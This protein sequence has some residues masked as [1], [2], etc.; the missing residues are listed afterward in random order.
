VTT[1]NS[2]PAG[3]IALQTN[4]GCFGGATGALDLVPSGGS[5]PYT[6]IWSN[7][8]TTEDV[9]NLA[10]GTFNVIITDANNCKTAINATITQP[11]AA[12]AV[13]AS[14][15]DVSCFGYTNGSAVAVV[16]GGT[17]PYSYSWDT[18]PVQ[19]TQTVADLAPGTY[20]VNIT[21]AMG[22]L[23]LQSVQISEPPELAIGETH[24]DASC[25]DEPDGFITLT[26]TGGTGPYSALWSD[27]FNTLNRADIDTGNYRVIVTDS[28]GCSM[29]ADIVIDFEGTFNCVMIPQVITPN[30]DGYNDTWIIRN[31]DLYPNAEVLVFNRWGD[32]IFRTKNIL[33]NPW[34]GTFKG[35]LVPTDSYHYILYLNDGS[36]PK[37]GVI[38]VIR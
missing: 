11:I 15:T 21:D 29:P 28:L 12:L 7:G 26:V 10:A 19:S 4:V 31:I 1:V 27:G 20:T 14:K 13:S 33:A 9:N 30:G 32:L 37:S 6:Y 18:S 35:K 8:E 16:T 36:E 22:C 17:T 24:Q 5:S 23:I 34:D 2:L 3:T 25:P 38:S